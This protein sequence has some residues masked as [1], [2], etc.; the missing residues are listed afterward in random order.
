[1]AKSQPLGPLYAYSRMRH[2]IQTIRV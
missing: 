2:E 1:L